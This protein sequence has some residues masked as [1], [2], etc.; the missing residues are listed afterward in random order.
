MNI[1]L[2]GIIYMTQLLLPFLQN[3]DDRIDRQDKDERFIINTSSIAGIAT[4]DSFYAVT[5]HGVCALSEVFQ[6]ELKAYNKICK[7]KK[8]GRGVINVSCLIPSYVKSKFL[9]TVG[10]IHDIQN[11]YDELKKEK[12][13]NSGR[14]HPETWKRN[15][16]DPNLVA[17]IVFQQGIEQKLFWIHTHSDWSKCSSVD[18][19]YSIFTQKFNQY[20]ATK[21]VF[22]KYKQN[23]KN[24]MNKKSKL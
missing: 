15:G 12:T 2:W 8:Q 10:K 23:L 4:A 1:N 6:S 18:R 24:V 22:Q 20:E 21:K 11:I 3:V 17:D 14:P 9:E 5:K 16:I 13:Y 19:F 7:A